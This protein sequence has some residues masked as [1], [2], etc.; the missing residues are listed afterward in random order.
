M[1]SLHLCYTDMRICAWSQATWA[2]WS[3]AGRHAERWENNFSAVL[4]AAAAV[5]RHTGFLTPASRPQDLIMNPRC[6]LMTVAEEK[7][8]PSTHARSRTRA[9]THTHTHTHTPTPPPLS[10]PPPRCLLSS[11]LSPSSQASMVTSPSALAPPPTLAPAWHA[12]DPPP[13]P[14]G[15]QGPGPGAAPAWNRLMLFS[16][17]WSRRGVGSLGQAGSPEAYILASTEA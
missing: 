6:F 15:G 16:R 9:H 11:P 12:P 1:I 14:S 8:S 4:P 5:G 17:K 7:P 10:E 13:Q 2:A 3:Y